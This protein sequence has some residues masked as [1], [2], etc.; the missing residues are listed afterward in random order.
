MKHIKQ[1]ILISIVILCSATILCAQ[2]YREI[3]GFELDTVK[4][5]KTRSDEEIKAL[6]VTIAAGKRPLG[7]ILYG[8]AYQT[9]VPVGLEI[10]NPDLQPNYHF[11]PHL[12]VGDG[13]KPGQIV[14]SDQSPDQYRSAKE[15]FMVSADNAR[16]DN[17]LDDLVEKLDEFTWEINDGVVNI[18]PKGKR[19]P[20]VETFLNTK[21]SR[22]WFP[23]GVQI[24]KFFDTIRDL[25][26]FKKSRFIITTAGGT[27][28]YGRRFT[29]TEPVS[30]TDV[31]VRELLNRLAKL[32]QC[33]W[34]VFPSA[35]KERSK[36]NDVIFLIL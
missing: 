36:D 31:T 24:G 3:P 28:G 14:V 4:L 21:I 2:Q 10:G 11:N 7:A 1:P 20:A 15:L 34:Y 18:R 30:L 27:F 5:L 29:L 22:F 19:D 16:L 12:S 6:R 17:F 26:E 32:N 35:D 13:S 23:A 8:I 9:G 33:G 25:P